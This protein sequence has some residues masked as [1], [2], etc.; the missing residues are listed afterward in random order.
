MKYYPANLDINNRK[1]LVAGGGSVAERKVNTLTECGADVTVVSPEVSDRLT[2]LADSGAITIHKRPFSSSDLD[3]M[4][5]VIGA[6]DDETLN[7]RISSDA[8]ERNMLCNIADVPGECSFILPAVVK[9]GDL[10]LSISTSGT[11]PAFAKKLRKDLEKEFGEEYARFLSL[12]GAIR[13]K[14]L[15]EA[16]ESETNRS[17]F[18]QLISGGLLEMVKNRETDNINRLLKKVLGDNYS[19]EMLENCG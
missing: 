10:V 19:L 17:C 18:E 7:R 11:S 14:R 3:G 4:F 15:Q 1:C 5:L 13:E 12:M 16:Q 2:R 6:T 8:A 9:R